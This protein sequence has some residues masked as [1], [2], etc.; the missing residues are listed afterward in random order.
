MGEAEKREQIEITKAAILE[1]HQSGVFHVGCP[2]NGVAQ[3]QVEKIKA[4]EPLPDGAV[5]MVVMTW[6]VLNGFGKRVGNAL[7]LGLFV[8]LILTLLAGVFGIWR[9]LEWFMGMK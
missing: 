4:M 3:E 5:K 2:W 1:L 8:V 7:A 6:N 9:L